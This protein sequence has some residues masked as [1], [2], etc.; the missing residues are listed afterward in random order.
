MNNTIETTCSC[1]AFQRGYSDFYRD[2]PYQPH[3]YT[4]EGLIPQ[5]VDKAEMSNEDLAQ[6]NAGWCEA[7][8]L[9]DKA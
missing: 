1:D 7:R 5:R 8:R 9:G 6:Y 4:F 3:Y 2:R